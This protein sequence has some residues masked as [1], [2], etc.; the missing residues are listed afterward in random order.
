MMRR[1]KLQTA[2][3]PA[4]HEA[5]LTKTPRDFLVKDANVRSMLKLGGGT[6]CDNRKHTRRET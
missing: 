5:A 6:G 1:T 4:S 3:L 2:I